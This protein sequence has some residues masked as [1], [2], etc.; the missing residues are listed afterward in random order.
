MRPAFDSTD[1]CLWLATYGDYRPNLPLRGDLSVDVAVVGAGFTGLSTAYHLRRDHPELRVAVFEAEVVGYGASGRNGGFSMTLFGFEP[2]VTK[3][4]FGH[5]RT[6]EA[7]RYM[8]RAVDSV[9]ALVRE[10]QLQSDYWFPGFLRVATQPIHVRRMQ[11]SMR[12]LT[13]MGI[14]GIEWWEASRARAEID[15]PRVLGAWWEPR[16]G[17]LN[18]AK[19]VRELKRVAEQAGATV[20]ERTPVTQINRGPQFT[21]STPG[22]MITADKLVLATNAYSHLIPELWLRQVPVFTHMVATEPLAP[23]QR[24]A[25][26][27]QRRQG[28]EDARNLVHY[29]RLTADD[30]LAIGGADVTLA[31]GRDMDRDLNPH[32]FALLEHDI[33]WLFPALQGIRITHRWGGP[34]SV[35]TQMVPALGY[36]GDPRAVYSVGCM[37]HGVSLAHL[38]GQTLA[39]LLCEQRSELT[40]AWFVNRRV[41][42]WPPEPLRYGVSALI[43]SALQWDDRR[44]E[45][46]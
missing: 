33:G 38:N 18:P 29:L 13:D 15:S 19:H 5:Q 11:D 8:E 28:V 7:H 39:D 46:A 41:L 25:I 2:S 42:P 44:H 36:L 16:C 34:V 20:F 22:G 30:R 17:L 1:R 14:T 6:V 21:L 4:F 24:D 35:T 27:W 37:G 3:R 43:L 26:G 9:D 12:I 23:A 31:Y 10:H 32:T 40:E 45:R